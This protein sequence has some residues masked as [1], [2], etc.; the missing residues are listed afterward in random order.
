MTHVVHDEAKP[1]PTTPADN[2]ASL[3]GIEVVVDDPETSWGLWN[4]AVAGLAPAIS[5]KTTDT[6]PAALEAFMGTRPMGLEDKT[7]EQRNNDALAVIE[8]PHRKIADAIRATW[9]FRECEGYIN[10]LVLSGSDGMGQTRVGFNP[11]VIDALMALSDLHES[12]FGRMAQEEEL[13][14]ADSTVR[15]GL[16]GVR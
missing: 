10:K 2:P 4:Q 12:Q 6:Q 5:S 7:P 9:G 3:G 16:D 1:P 13:G 14:F 8:G 15:S 11:L